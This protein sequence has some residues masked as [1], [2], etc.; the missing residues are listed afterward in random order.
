[1]RTLLD[2]AFA[3][4]GESP[5]AAAELDV[6]SSILSAVES[7]MGDTILPK[8]DF[9]DVPGSTRM[10]ATPIEPPL[11][12]TASLISSQDGP[13]TRAV[14]AVHAAFVDFAR[15]HLE[16]HPVPGAEWIGPGGV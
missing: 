11:Y 10:F 9:S 3:A 1:V 16:A 7:G 2:R 4:A 14:T 12:L 6:F 8:G 5:K 15:R 13:A